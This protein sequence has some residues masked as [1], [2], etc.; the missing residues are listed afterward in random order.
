MN[1]W[2]GR[3]W[4]KIELKMCRCFICFTCVSWWC[5][6]QRIEGRMSEGKGWERDPSVWSPCLWVIVPRFGAFSERVTVAERESGKREL[7]CW[8]GGGKG[9]MTNLKK[10]LG[11]WM[12]MAAA[13]LSTVDSVCLLLTPAGVH[14]KMPPSVCVY[15]L[16]SQNK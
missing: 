14:L 15:E 13:K 5:G 11:I 7:L 2:D 8:G 6:K 10:G 16:N 4:F 3:R 1:E 12:R 9:R